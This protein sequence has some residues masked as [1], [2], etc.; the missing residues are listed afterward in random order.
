MLS[1]Q[2][3]CAVALLLYTTGAGFNGRAAAQDVR[4]TVVTILATDRN[5]DVDSKLADVAA[6]VKKREPSL[7]GY[8]LGKTG[9][10]DINVGQKEAI[11]LFDDKDYSTDVKL[12]AKNDSKKR[13]TLE[14]K[15][16]MVGAIS[17]EICYDKF[18]PIVTR[19]V[20]D[21]ERLIIAVMV[22]PAEKAAKAT[23]PGP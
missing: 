8:R 19:A 6:E 18:F 12:L 9:H 16:P 13:V 3:L 21:G 7:T 17:Y 14:V 10:R 11:K 22:R 4:V 2:T 23:P 5:Q 15:P 20:V 1:R